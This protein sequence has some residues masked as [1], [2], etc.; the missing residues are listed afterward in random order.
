MQL[1]AQPP[2]AAIGHHPHDFLL[3]SHADEVLVVRRRSQANDL[4]RRK[5]LAGVGRLF[6][7]DGGLA[8]HDKAIE[9]FSQ[10]DGNGLG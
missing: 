4:Q 6:Q 3:L 7:R 8:F 10:Q 1:S 9:I 2:L 5:M